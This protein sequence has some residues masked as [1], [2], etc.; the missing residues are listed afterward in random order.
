[1]ASG[2]G[3]TR[4]GD[5]A[6][7]KP[8]PETLRAQLTVLQRKEDRAFD[9]HERAKAAYDQARDVLVETLLG[10]S[11]PPTDRERFAEQAARRKQEAAMDRM[12]D[13]LR[14]FRSA[15]HEVNV[16]RTAYLRAV[17]ARALS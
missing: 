12:H 6:L 7:R 15:L 4:S 5:S 13:T 9:A 1:M 14:A 11:N 17:Q 2:I 10:R 16:V 3:C 8:T